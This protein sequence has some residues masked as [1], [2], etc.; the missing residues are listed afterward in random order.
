[1]TTLSAEEG[2]EY[3]NALLATCQNPQVKKTNEGTNSM[4]FRF[5]K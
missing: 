2:G 3:V 4:Q 1:M 5:L